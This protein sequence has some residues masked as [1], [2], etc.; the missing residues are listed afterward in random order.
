[1]YRLGVALAFLLLQTAFGLDYRT[2]Q[3]Q[4]YVS[5]Y[6]LVIDN[7]ARERLE[8]Y[9]AALEK[10]TG[11]QVAMVTLKSLEGENIEQFS[12]DLAR[13]WGIGKKGNDEGLLLLL[14]TDERQHRLEVGRGL[15]PIIPDGFAGR[16]LLAMRPALREQRYGDALIEALRTLGERI[17]QAKGV[18]IELIQRRGPPP[19]DDGTGFE[20]GIP[21][22]LIAFII[23][24]LLF[25]FGSR[26]GRGRGGR[27][28]GYAGPVFLPIPW[29]GGGS[30][31]G[32]HSGGGFGGYDSNGGFGGFGGGG[33]FGGGGAS[34]NW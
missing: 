12:N 21:W 24:L 16:V 29:G 22:P 26:G 23:V 34:S 25:G 7:Q 31:H 9:A 13:H 20:T 27:R 11:V 4:G 28:R 30:Y 33:D 6:A 18:T 19:A 14:V 32:G 3:P 17:A 15:E 5:D 2:L 8:N 10:S 1:M